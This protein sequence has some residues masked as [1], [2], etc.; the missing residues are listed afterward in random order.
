[1]YF[2]EARVK[3]LVLK[4]RDRFPG[5]ELVFD[6]YSPLHWDLKH[7]RD[8]ERWSAGIHLLEER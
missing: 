2:E 3:S 4:L 5:A 6:A 8:L 7:G 1:M